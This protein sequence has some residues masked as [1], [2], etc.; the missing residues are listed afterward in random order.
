MEKNKLKKAERFRLRLFH[1]I[2]GLIILVIVS[3]GLGS[4]MSAMVSSEKLESTISERMIAAF[5]NVFTNVESL[6]TDF[7]KI[8]EQGVRETSGLVALDEI[9]NIAQ[10]S[11]DKFHSYAQ[12]MITEVG[13][14]VGVSVDDLE[15]TMGEGFDSTLIVASNSIGGIIKESVKSQEVLGQVANFRVEALIQTSLD[16]FNKVEEELSN[17][18]QR[19]NSLTMGFQEEIDDNTIRIV[20]SLGS[21]LNQEDAV[22][23]DEVRSQIMLLQEEVKSKIASA[24]EEIYNKVHED[25][26]RIVRVLKEQMRLMDLKMKSDGEQEKIISSAILGGLFE[27]SIA[28]VIEIQT[29]ARDRTLILEDN[30]SKK[31][32]GLKIDLPRELKAYGEEMRKEMDARTAETVKG[33]SDVIE[34]ARASLNRSQ[35]EAMTKLNDIQ[36]SSIIET[37]QSIQGIGKGVLI[38]LILAMALMALFFI[39]LSIIIV[40]RS[41]TNPIAKLQQRANVMGTGDLTREVSIDTNDEIGELAGAFNGLI[42]SLRTVIT[43]IRDAGFQITSSASQINASAE[44]QVSGAAEQS[45]AVSE[46]SVT[47]KELATSASQIAENAENVAKIAEKTLFGMQEINTRVD[48]TAKKILILG[49]RSQSIGSITK[50]ID[51]IAEQTNLL[52]L[53]AAIEAARAG[54]AGKGFAVVAQEVRK[55][56]E[57]SSESTNEIRQLITEIQGET[58]ST[59]MEIENSTKWVAAGLDMVKDTTR[60]AKEISLATQQQKTASNQVVRA[61][62]NIDSVTKQFVSSTK[63]AT[64]SIAKLNELSQNLKL[65]IGG[66]KLEEN[67]KD[68]KSS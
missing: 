13:E 52:A 16:G 62:Q 67:E 39:G 63:Q 58:N 60:V 49:E 1:K 17:F 29:Q 15:E 2:L 65:V 21:G 12:K 45:T 18:K 10:K 31:I 37:K 34:G 56:A 57:R 68:S 47:I 11:Q 22:S 42:G 4:I 14:D 27:K 8:A 23:V 32:D 7:Q 44:Q 25:I 55:L 40:A 5:E 66:F 48:Q 24:N 26:S 54:E 51:N 19:M 30:L 35:E 33:A 28:Q 53:N 3:S 46:V 64:S 20:A 61:M 6:F 36:N 59:I 38:A 41:I 50:L 43:Q 9:K